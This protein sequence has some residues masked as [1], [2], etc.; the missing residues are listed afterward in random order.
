MEYFYIDDTNKQQGPF[1]L[2]EL[3]EKGLKRT[4]KMWRE[5][6]SEWLEA[7]EINELNDLFPSPPPVEPVSKPSPPPPVDPVSGT[8]S[9]ETVLASA[10]DRFLA[11]LIDTLLVGVV[12]II[13]IIGWIAGPVYILLAD[14]VP[15]LD[16]QSIGKQAL[17]IRVV[18]QETYTPITDDYGASALR[19]VSLMIPIFSLVDACMVFSEDRLRF[20]DQWAKTTVIKVK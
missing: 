7:S 8:A 11:Y 1:S 12:F 16:G 4:S 20:G 9:N 19:K 6:M 2:E 13:P 14:A 5:G 17:N 18:K 3:K 15:F 10:G